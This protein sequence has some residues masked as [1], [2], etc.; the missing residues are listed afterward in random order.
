MRRGGGA[1]WIGSFG[2]RVTRG[3]T[4]TLAATEAETYLTVS[5]TEGATHV[6]FHRDR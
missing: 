3:G 4:G 1:A 2:A 5:D 6:R